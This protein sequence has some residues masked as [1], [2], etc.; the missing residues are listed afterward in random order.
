[1]ELAL[2]SQRLRVLTTNSPISQS[3]NT[4]SV[5]LPV[6]RVPFLGYMEPADA[7][8]LRMIHIPGG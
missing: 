5:H 4:F 8:S 1:M 2:L 3:A 7:P 6:K